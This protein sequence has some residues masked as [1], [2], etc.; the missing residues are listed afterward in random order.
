MRRRP[1]RDP[2]RLGGLV[3]SVLS[4]LGHGEA[5]ESLRVAACWPAVVGEEA[6]AHADP[7]G[8]RG[9][10]LEV[11]VH[12][13]VWAQHLQMRRREILA[14]L[15]RELGPGAPRELRFRVGSGV[16]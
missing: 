8:L 4:E 10:V 3:G 12:S 5:S 9:G 15:A 11:E 16:G 7:V 2:V 14:G 1:K 6:A 13:S